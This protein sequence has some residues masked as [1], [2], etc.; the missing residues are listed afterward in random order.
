MSDERGNFHG[1]IGDHPCSFGRRP[2]LRMWRNTETCTS[3]SGSGTF[4]TTP[5]PIPA[6]NH[7]RQLAIHRNVHCPRKAASD[8]CRQYRPGWCCGQRG[9]PRR[10]FK[11]FRPINHHRLD[12]YGDIGRYISDL[13]A[14]EWA[15][16]HFDRQPRRLR[17]QRDLPNQRWMRRG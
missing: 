16:R 3:K 8:L 14:P 11:L 1:S 6:P 12:W 17:F 10:R 4:H 13:R 15:G 2:L 7:S 5:D 9:T